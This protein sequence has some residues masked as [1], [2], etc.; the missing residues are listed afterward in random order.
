MI[1]FKP[2]TIEDKA[3]ITSYTLSSESRDCDFSFANLCCWHFLNDSSYAIIDNHLVI[4]FTMD[5]DRTEYFMPM[6]KG[7]IRPVM[8]QLEQLTQAEGSP[9][10]L[11]G[12]LLETRRILERYYPTIFEYSTNRDYFD[13]I[14]YR[15]DLIEL[16][17]KN[18]QPKR[19]HVNKFKKE[20][21]YEYL[22]LTPDL[23]PECLQFEAD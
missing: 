13:Y 14:Y 19:N 20:Y 9:L 21:A 2:I 17:G 4:R 23:M 15:R 11:R 8:E 22:P 12:Q 1:H 3:V 7:D 10:Y 18:Y 6:G 16:K 5:N